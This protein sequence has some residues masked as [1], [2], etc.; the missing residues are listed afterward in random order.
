MSG[1]D[2]TVFPTVFDKAEQISTVGNTGGSTTRFYLRKNPLY[3]G[4]IAVTNGDFSFSFI[5]P[6]D[7]AYNYGFGKISYYARDPETDANGYN[8]NIIVG[9][10]ANSK[11]SDTEGPVLKLFMNDTNFISGGITDQNPALL[12][13]IYDSSGINTVGS[14]IGHDITAVLDN[15]TR[16]S[17]ILNDYYVSDLD[18]YKSGEIY[19]PFF[20]LAEGTHQISLKVWDVYNNSAEGTIDFVVYSTSQFALQNLMNF[21]N[22]FSDHTT[23]SFEYNQPDATLDVDLKIFSLTGRLIKTLHEV[24]NTSGYRVETIVWDGTSDDGS[25]ISAGMYVY[26]LNASLPD[27]STVRK[28]SKLIYFK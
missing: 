23:F 2:G 9:G 4:K 7:I 11:N 25:K 13:F 27:G 28:S 12:A 18:T 14:G 10:F 17:Y 6:K 15:D 16:N 22:P 20:S 5:V 24:V 1:F 8:D 19:Y 21:P 26:Y 3:K